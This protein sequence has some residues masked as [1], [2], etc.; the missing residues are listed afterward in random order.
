MPSPSFSD[1]TRARLTEALVDLPV[2][3]LPGVALFPG[4]RMRLHIFE[5]RYREMLAHCLRSHGCMAM[6]QLTPGVLLSGGH[7]AFALTAGVG[8]IEQHEP[9]PDGRAHIVLA[10][11]AR[12]RL[13][14][15][16]FVPPFRRATA[17]ILP[18]G[19][20]PVDSR[21]VASLAL[22]ATRFAAELRA[23]DP[24]VELAL[25]QHANTAEVADLL[26]QDL[27]LDGGDRQ[28]LMDE[29]DPARRVDML[30]RILAMQ[31]DS[32]RPRSEGSAAN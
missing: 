32:M 2:F 25:P 20:T 3:P 14:E 18:D 1:R 10:G 13:T 16:P 5:P 19:A 4:G 21:D 30:M 7:P 11:L 15:K 12:V 31:W 27:V 6:A 24:G 29:R 22:L 23:H 8:I 9:L 26:A 17:E 28:R